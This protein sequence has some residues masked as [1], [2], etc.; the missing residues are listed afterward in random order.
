MH[1]S[2]ADHEHIASD[3]HDTRRACDRSILEGFDQL[4]F[5]KQKGIGHM[6]QGR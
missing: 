6:T 3:T 5:A 2:P 4:P 1:S